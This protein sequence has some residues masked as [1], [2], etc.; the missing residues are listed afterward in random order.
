MNILYCGDSNIE[1]GLIIS[2][3]SIMKHNSDEELCIYVLTMGL[4]VGERKFRPVSD[5]IISFL[6]G[7]VKKADKRSFVMKLDITERFLEELPLANLETRFTPY[8]MLRLFADELDIL[9]SRILYLDN[10]VVCRESISEFYHQDM[11][12]FEI[13]GTLDYYG[14]W[15]FRRDLFHLD[16]LNSGVLL[17]NLAEIR[18][19][20]VFAACR[21]RCREKK[22]FMPDQSAINK[23]SDKRKQMPRK[24]NDQRKLHKDTVLQHFTTSFR[25]F[26]WVRTVSVKPWQVEKVHSV[27]HLH[28]YDDILEEYGRICEELQS[29]DDSLE[30]A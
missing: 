28:E 25:F 16:Y 17:L 20:G 15:F 30:E 2:I 1:G 19:S 12:G 24:Y 23:L 11:E 14:R 6:D 21:K 13:A 4:E 26:P 27:L 8:C 5:R 3:L 10:D 29:G 18:K 22:M 9:P 7:I